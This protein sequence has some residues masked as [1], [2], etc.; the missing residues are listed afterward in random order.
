[1]VHKFT[2]GFTPPATIDELADRTV[3]LAKKTVGKSADRAFGPATVVPADLA[4][5]LF[6]NEL[7]HAARAQ[8]IHAGVE[9]CGRKEVTFHYGGEP[10]LYPGIA[11]D[12]WVTVDGKPDAK[13]GLKVPKSWQCTRLGNARFRILADGKVADRNSLKVSLGGKT[14]DF[15]MLGPGEA[16]G[17]PAGDNVATCPRCHARVEACI[18][19]K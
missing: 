7:A 4:S 5:R 15:T 19:E 8:D 14:A 11:R 10:V 17:F 3:A 16:K 12:V 1:I 6:R 9:L 18:C 13:V 2:R